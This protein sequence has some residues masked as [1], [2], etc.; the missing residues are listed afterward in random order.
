MKDRILLGIEQFNQLELRLRLMLTFATA[1]LL[2]LIIDLLFLSSVD[3]AITRTTSNIEQIEQQNNQ[4]L[5]TQATL[6]SS[7]K[8]NRS[9]PKVKQLML[10]KS[11]VELAHNKLKEKSVTLVPVDKMA[12]LL[13]TIIDDAKSLKLLKLEK[14]PPLS[15]L[16]K[17]AE[18]ESDQNEQQLQVYRHTIDLLLSG[19]YTETL[20]FIKS[21]ESMQQKVDFGRFEFSVDDYPHSSIKLEV[22]TISFNRKW[23]GG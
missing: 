9:N 11:E 20:L 5:V 10:L 18:Q 6:S 23:I 19:N 8:D 21:L 2:W 4:L 22:S 16:L 7:L 12:S 15:L 17:D 1:L 14:K 13:R 3:K